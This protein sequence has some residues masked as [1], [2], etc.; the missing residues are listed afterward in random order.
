M[1]QL[2]EVEQDESWIGNYNRLTFSK[3]Y[4]LHQTNLF[5]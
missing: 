1:Y 4:T 2:M 3:Y 5:Q